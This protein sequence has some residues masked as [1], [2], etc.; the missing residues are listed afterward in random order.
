MLIDKGYITLILIFSL[1]LFFACSFWGTLWYIK[2]FTRP[3]TTATGDVE[4]QRGKGVGARGD[5]NS[6]DK[7]HMG[8]VQM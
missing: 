4:L 6:G 1:V 7:S 8:R 2:H 3:S 5:E